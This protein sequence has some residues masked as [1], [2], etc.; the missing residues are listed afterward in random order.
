MPN[1]DALRTASLGALSY[2]CRPKEL[3]P[4]FLFQL[5]SSLDCIAGSGSA[6]GTGNMRYLSSVKPWPQLYMINSTGYGCPYLSVSTTE[7]AGKEWSREF[8]CNWIEN[9]STLAVSF[10]NIE[11]ARS[12]TSFVRYSINGTSATPSESHTYSATSHIA[13]VYKGGTLRI[14]DGGTLVDVRTASL[15]N[16]PKLMAIQ[17]ETS[18]A[19]VLVSNLRLVPVAL[20]TDTT[21]PVPTALYTGQEPLNGGGVILPRSS[22]VTPRRRR[23]APVA[24]MGGR[25]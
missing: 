24:V 10:A 25:A 3:K 13:L 19:G 8:M 9:A 1:F 23:I 5:T 20:G 4:C 11:F 22:K 12:K 14:F 16:N 21:Y 6:S 15:P 18:N 17:N 7:E 2:I